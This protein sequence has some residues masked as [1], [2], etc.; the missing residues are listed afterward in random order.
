MDN[1]HID[2]TTLKY[3]MAPTGL[4]VDNYEK[5][6]E[7]I[8][9]LNGPYM[10]VY[11]TF[12]KD[13]ETAQICL[14][15]PG[16]NYSYHCPLEWF[17]EARGLHKHVFVELMFVIRGTISQR[18]EENLY[19]YSEG[20]CC[21]IM[22][23]V[24]HTETAI[25]DAE[26][27]FFMISDEFL[28]DIIQMDHRFSPDGRTA[29]N[30]N[31]LYQLFEKHLCKDG[32]TKQYLD[33]LPTAP[34]NNVLIP[35][36]KYLTQITVE[37]GELTP[38]FYALIISCAERLIA[39][40]L[41]PLLYSWRVISEGDQYQENL[42]LKIRT[43]L[44]REHGRISRRD[45]AA[46]LGYSDHHINRIVQKNTNMTLSKYS[47]IFT[48]KEA[49]RRLSETDDSISH[50]ILSLGYTNRSHFYTHFKQQYGVLPNEYRRN[51]I[52]QTFIGTN[53]I[54]SN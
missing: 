19:E 6:T 46:E 38:G 16:F 4:R 41:D 47:R 54:K 33:F 2:L 5:G 26:L 28:S 11:E 53:N 52:T 21:V 8:Y 48:L 15:A 3:R 44:A 23:G 35:I 36:K 1:M 22:P 7:G 39:S 14:L 34:T 43:I 13:K 45:L 42:F 31:I 20:Q 18:I 12:I 51:G 30:N 27:V 50:I 10:V 29:S 9:S 37:T 25:G 24:C 17:S 32:L 40:M 49:A